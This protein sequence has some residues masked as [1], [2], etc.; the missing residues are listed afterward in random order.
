VGWTINSK[1]KSETSI[2]GAGIGIPVA[3]GELKHE[4][5]SIEKEIPLTSVNITPQEVSLR[6]P[7]DATLIIIDDFER[8]GDSKSRREFADFIKKLSDNNVPTTLIIVG[9]AENVEELIKQL[10]H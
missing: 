4:R 10:N 3:K 6:L 8:I 7:K 2:K 1:E 5:T 9:I